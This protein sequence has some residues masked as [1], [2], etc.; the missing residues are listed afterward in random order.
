MAPAAKLKA[1]PPETTSA[2]ATLAERCQQYLL[3][4]TQIPDVD[5]CP[6]WEAT[7]DAEEKVQALII[8]PGFFV[9]T[10]ALN[11]SK[12]VGVRKGFLWAGTSTFNNFSEACP[13]E[14]I[15]RA[16]LLSLLKL[17]TSA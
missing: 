9:A 4:M 6:I 17:K 11:G 16:G 15:Q 1:M 7:V 10:K 3:G 14:I 2:K 8:P 13:A 5:A 12:A